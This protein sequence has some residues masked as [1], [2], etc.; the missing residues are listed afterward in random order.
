MPCNSPF[1]N[2][3]TK[4]FSDFWN[5]AD[6]F[7]SDYKAQQIKIDL[8]DENIINLFYLLYARYGNSTIANFDENQFK[9]SVW[10]IIF[11]YGPTWQKK[12]DLQKKIRDLTEN[13]LSEG[14]KTIQN[15]AFN[16]GTPPTTKS[17]EETNFINDQQTTNFKRSKMNA[18]Q[19]Q[20][21]LLETD[22][23]EQFL[24]KFKDL[25]LRIVQPY[26]PLYYKTE[27][28][29]GDDTNE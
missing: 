5:S 24:S 22:V 10:G 20:W 7:L 12:L 9:Y 28:N 6:K 23:T 21:Q 3:R 16:D 4:K 19:L 25:F 26:S 14:N 13:E 11:Q 1:G 15:H 29:Q 2:F 17:L 18:Y 8:S 27:L